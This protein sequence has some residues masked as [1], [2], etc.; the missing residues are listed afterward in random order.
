MSIESAI[1]SP[2][3]GATAVT[4][5]VGDRVSPYIDDEGADFPRI[6]YRIDAD[7]RIEQLIQN[8]STRVATVSIDCIARSETSV[9][10]LADAVE[11]TIRGVSPKG[12]S[13]VIIIQDSTG[14]GAPPFDGSRDP[15]YTRTF[16]NLVF[17]WS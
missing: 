5:L 4:S 8:D 3:T 13:G 1:H 6:V 11:R 7:E 2:L 17:Y 16:T 15:V 9:S 12:Y 10:S 14:D